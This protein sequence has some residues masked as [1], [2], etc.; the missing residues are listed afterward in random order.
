MENHKIEKL[1]KPMVGKLYEYQKQ[2]LMVLSYTIGGN[3]IKIYC[4]GPKPHITIMRDDLEGVLQSFIEVSTDRAVTV[5]QGA[6]NPY[7]DQPTEGAP[8]NFMRN[9]IVGK[10]AGKLS[11]IIM[12]SIEKLQNDPSYISQAEAVNAQV[13]S[14]IE[15]GKSEIEMFKVAA[16]MSK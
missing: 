5:H 7:L 16:Y 14:L 8:A 15:L 12:A 10:N 1:I 4:D 6:V 13:K 3:V 11:E 9:T 2:E